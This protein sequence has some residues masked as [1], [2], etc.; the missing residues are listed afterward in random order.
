MYTEVSATEL[1]CGAAAPLLHLCSRLRHIISDLRKSC[2]VRCCHSSE[3]CISSHAHTVY[4]H[5]HN[6]F[7]APFLYRGT[8]KRLILVVVFPPGSECNPTA[9]Q[10]KEMRRRRGKESSRTGSGKRKTQGLKGKEEVKI[11]ANTGRRVIT[12]VR[13]RSPLVCRF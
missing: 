11:W 1:F 3:T 4:Q 8:I 2:S 5:R 10:K 12:C 13:R 7:K 9:L 6:T